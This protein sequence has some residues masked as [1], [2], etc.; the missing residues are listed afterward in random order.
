MSRT[1][2][3][4]G[5]MIATGV[6]TVAFSEGG[7]QPGIEQLALILISVSAILVIVTTVDPSLRRQTDS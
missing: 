2:Q 7:H 5:A 6:I 1:A 3:Y 4:L